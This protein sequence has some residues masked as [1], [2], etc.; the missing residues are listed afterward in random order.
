M[1]DIEEAFAEL[2]IGLDNLRQALAEDQPDDMDEDPE[3]TVA[4]MINRHY[5]EVKEAEGA[6]RAQEGS[7]ED[8][9]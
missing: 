7:E 8:R 4:A 2:R 3:V 9:K 1:A 5:E 6:R